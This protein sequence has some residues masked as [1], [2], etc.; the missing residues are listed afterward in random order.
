MQTDAAVTH[1]R[2]LLVER[3][4]ALLD[5]LDAHAQFTGDLRL[6]LLRLGDELVERRIEQAEDHRLAV[7]DA[8]RA[9]DRSLD[10]R[11]EVGQGGLALLVGIA[12]DHL[13]QLGQRRLGIL[14]VEHVLDTE[15]ADALR[16]ELEG[17]GGI[18]G[19]VGVGADTQAAELVHHVHELDE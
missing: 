8:Q 10:V 3:L 11:L 2:V 5:L 6:L 4:A 19:R 7:H 15:Q 14:A 12:E 13:A 1:H 16:S 17:L 9:L 18:L